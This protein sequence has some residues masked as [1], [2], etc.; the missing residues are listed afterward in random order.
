MD[1]YVEFQLLSEV[2]GL[3]SFPNP[4]S[5]TGNPSQGWESEGQIRN[6]ALC[7][8]LCA[9]SPGSW[10]LKLNCGSGFPAAIQMAPD[11]FISA[12]SPPVPPTPGS[13]NS[14]DVVLLQRS[15]EFPRFFHSFPTPDNDVLAHRS[16]STAT[17]TVGR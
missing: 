13:F 12:F 16:G 3:Y 10:L 5:E 11:F 15:R 9:T 2:S 4:Q 7:P 6:S 17:K 14:N 8:M 1:N